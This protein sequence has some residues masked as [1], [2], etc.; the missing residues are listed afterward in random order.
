MTQRSGFTGT[1][2][3]TRDTAHAVA[4]GIANATVAARQQTLW[5]EGSTAVAEV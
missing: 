4:I 3:T 2:R 1:S 5:G